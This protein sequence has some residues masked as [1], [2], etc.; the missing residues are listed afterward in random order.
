MGTAQARLTPRARRGVSLVEILVAMTLLSIVAGSLAVLSTKN[1]RRGRD[2]ELTAARTFLMLQQANRFTTLPY[3]SLFAYAPRVDTVRAGS[4]AFVRR[5]SLT[6]PTTGSEYRTVQVLLVPLS[7][8]TRRDSLR[9][10]RAKTYA[11]SPLF[12]Q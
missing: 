1:A 6:A 8:S 12:V 11:F 2:V 5:V 9:F 7:D 10:V 3:D 4:L